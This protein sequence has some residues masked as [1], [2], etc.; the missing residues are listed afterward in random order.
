VEGEW[1]T[2]PL[3]SFPVLTSVASSFIVRFYSILLAVSAIFLDLDSAV[4][5]LNGSF[6]DV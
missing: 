4:S 6:F 1:W 2:S 5:A 3:F